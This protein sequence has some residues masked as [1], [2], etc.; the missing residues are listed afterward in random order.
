VKNKYGKHLKMLVMVFIISCLVCL[1]GATLKGIVYLIFKLFPE[2]WTIELN[3]NGRPQ[4]YF[5]PKTGMV[6]QKKILK[7]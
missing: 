7:F 3:S 2:M 6:S 1:A 4:G 5:N